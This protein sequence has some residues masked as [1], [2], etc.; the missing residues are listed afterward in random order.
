[1]CCSALG[2]RSFTLATFLSLFFAGVKVENM[3]AERKKAK[4]GHG[5]EADKERQDEKQA[6]ENVEKKKS[7]KKQTKHEGG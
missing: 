6:D 5:T 4:E 1:M 7:G 3:A 2:W